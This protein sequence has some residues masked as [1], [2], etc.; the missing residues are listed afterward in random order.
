MA[1]GR[2]EILRN[3][4]KL[5]LSCLCPTAVQ[6]DDSNPDTT[7]RDDP[8]RTTDVG[9][10]LSLESPEKAVTYHL[11]TTMGE[12]K[13]LPEVIISA[14][15]EDDSKKSI[16]V[17]KQQIYISKKIVICSSSDSVPYHYV[18]RPISSTC[19]TNLD[20]NNLLEELTTTILTST[21]SPSGPPNRPSTANPDVEELLQRLTNIIRQY[22]APTSIDIPCTS[23][24]IDGLL[25]ELRT[26]LP[27]Y[28][29][30]ASLKTILSQYRL[31]A[32]ADTHCTD[33]GINGL[34]RELNTALGTSY[35]L[36][37][38]LSSLLEPFIVPGATVRDDI[39]KKLEDEDQKMRQAALVN[40]QIVDPRVPPRRV[41]DLYSNRVVPLWKIPVEHWSKIWAIS[42]AWMDEND[43]LDVWTPINGR[44]WPVPVPKGADLRLIRI[45]LLN[46]GAEYVW[47]DV[48]CLRRRG[49][50]R[51]DLCEDEWKLDVRTVGNVYEKAERVVCYFSGLGLPLRFKMNDFTSDRSWFKRAWILQQLTGNYIIGGQPSESGEEDMGMEKDVKTEFDKKLLELKNINRSR[52]FDVLRHMRDRV[53]IN[54][55]DR[56]AG[57][58]YLL[59]SQKLPTYYEAKT[60]EE[61]W[62]MLVETMDERNR[63]KLLFLYPEP[64]KARKLWGPSW[65]QVMAENLPTMD[66]GIQLY[67]NM[68]GRD[69]IMKT[70][71]Y[72]GY[73]IE[74]GCVRGL[75]KEGSEGELRRGE[76]IS[77][78][79]SISPATHQYPIPTASYTLIG[80]DPW[81]P[82]SG[83]SKDENSKQY[84]VV[85]E[86]RES[87]QMFKK[88][89]VFQIDNAGH[90]MNLLDES[91]IAQ[92]THNTLI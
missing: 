61:A 68:V 4:V 83:R 31:P 71:F 30:H 37:P 67:D 69:D 23:L 43:R 87:G 12:K 40:N 91:G 20:V 32:P 79:H 56:V 34:L 39:H 78:K 18:V 92:K 90:V 73:C 76:L 42:H 62:T 3:G 70:D 50:P 16:A 24:D 44:E 88:V 41:W 77:H 26:I 10:W 11:G 35:T 33:L 2:F 15:I 19:R 72:Y 63:A 25:E 54:A 80:S 49:G 85:G 38:D 52:V 6:E 82:Q 9:L 55:V 21:L 28:C 47:L 48:L 53:S 75:D 7:P 66:S 14:V 22:H 27:R 64:G 29:S 45:E 17:P 74:K 5:V 51:D 59:R 84:W 81:S 46:L 60:P 36:N 13:T 89:S 1:S 58:A 86:L 57:L 8:L 65:N